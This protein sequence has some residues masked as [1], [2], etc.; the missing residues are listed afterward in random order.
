MDV[1]I[2]KITQLV[3]SNPHS[4]PVVPYSS[5]VVPYFS[6]VVPYSSP[7]VAYFNFSFAE[8][9]KSAKQSKWPNSLQIGLRLEIWFTGLNFYLVFW[10][11]TVSLHKI[12]Q[13]AFIIAQNIFCPCSLLALGPAKCLLLQSKQMKVVTGLYK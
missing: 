8:I 13:M 7:V 12:L 11:K 1:K 3:T 2:Q 6:P 10:V 5:P 9:A 4:C